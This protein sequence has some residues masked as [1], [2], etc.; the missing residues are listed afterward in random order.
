VTGGFSRIIVHPEG[1]FAGARAMLAATALLGVGLGF[2]WVGILLVDIFRVGVGVCL[3]MGAIALGVSLAYA[4]AGTDRRRRASLGFA[5]GGDD[6]MLAL[7]NLV[8]SRF[9]DLN[10]RLDRH[11]ERHDEEAK[12]NEE[13]WA[14]LEARLKTEQDRDLT[15]EA[16]LGPIR[17][18]A[19]LLLDHWPQV[20]VL[21]GTLVGLGVVIG[22]QR[23]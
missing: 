23:P 11:E 6:G 16:R 17:S 2:I 5:S 19:R 3:S 14:P 21:A 7:T 22:W 12:R 13:R 10:A 18:L 9:D 4:A 15:I 20:T 8:I 1:W